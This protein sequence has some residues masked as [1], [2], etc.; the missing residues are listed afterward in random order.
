MSLYTDY[1]IQIEERKNQD[2]SPKP[3][4]DGALVVPGSVL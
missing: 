3:I 4:E 2:L 1:L